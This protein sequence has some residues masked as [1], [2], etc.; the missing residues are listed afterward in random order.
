VTVRFPIVTILALLLATGVVCA[1]D[2]TGIVDQKRELE[3]LQ[4]EMRDGQR[5]LDSLQTAQKRVQN[6]IAGYDQK[7]T[8]DRKVIRRLNKELDDLKRG[9]AI[10]DSTLGELR[11][12]LDR[13]QRRYLGG[14]RQFYMA[15]ALP[16]PAVAEAPNEELTRSSEVVYLTALAGFE[17]S[18]IQSAAQLLT[19]STERM[20][21]LA[22]RHQTIRGLK[23][24]RETSYALGTSQRQKQ[25]KSLEQLRRKSLVEADRVMMLQQAA[26]EMAAIIT[27]LEAKRSRSTDAGEAPAG[28]SAFA[29][30]KGRLPSPY[31]GKITESFGNHVHPVTKLKS[32]SPGITIE[33]RAGRAVLAV[34]S[35]KVAYAG[36]LRGYGN[37]VIIN[38]D[39]QYYTTY[40]GLGK[41]I[42]SENQFLQ[43]GDKL[44]ESGSD[45]IVK[46]E[47]R[48]GR[49]PLDPV[50]WIS[51]ES[52]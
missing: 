21:E 7:I 10:C 48:Q 2:K 13:Q 18:N 15:V 33:G 23:K 14:L 11:V 28:Q 1:D 49:E 17:S 45:G 25:E 31:Q 19:E 5:R 40:A 22:G 50:E 20:E 34:A 47:L 12:L 44:G 38:H 4:T 52:L 32:F 41:I 42:V 39:H 43:T 36:S 9:I 37:F 8:S 51:F 3:Q 46:F 30:L 29:G 26:E 6:Q 35:G 16:S 24:D 27:R